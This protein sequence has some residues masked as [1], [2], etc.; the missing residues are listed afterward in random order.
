MVHSRKPKERL[1]HLMYLNSFE[2]IHLILLSTVL[3]NFFGIV[4]IEKLQ[5]DIGGGVKLLGELWGSG[6]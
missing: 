2:I 4:A 1:G 6:C 5:A 3:Y